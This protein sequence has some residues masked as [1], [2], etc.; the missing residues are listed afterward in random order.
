MELFDDLEKDLNNKGDQIEIINIVF[1]ILSVLL[2]F[3]SFAF[4]I[5]GFKALKHKMERLC[6]IISRITEKEAM[7]E[8]DILRI[9]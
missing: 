6:Y 5:P 7:Y 2:L 3:M 9:F 4:I 8:I 1:F